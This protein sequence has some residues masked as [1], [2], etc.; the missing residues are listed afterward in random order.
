MK[1]LKL[2]AATMMLSLAVAPFAL[3][4]RGHFGGGA[5]AGGG[6]GFGGAPRMEGGAQPARSQM[7]G[8]SGMRQNFAG[9]DSVRDNNRDSGYRG[10]N[11]RDNS[12]R[13]FDRNNG[14]QYAAPRPP[15]NDNMRMRD[16]GREDYGDRA[17]APREASWRG[18]DRGRDGGRFVPR[19]GADGPRRDDYRWRDGRHE[20]DR[21]HDGGRYD[22]HWGWAARGGYRGEFISDRYYH[23]YW[24]P[25]HG[26]CFRSLR[27]SYYWGAPRYYYSGYWISLADPIPDYWGD[28]YDDDVYVEY[29][30]GGYYLLNRRW[31][32][33]PGVAISLWLR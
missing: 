26:F 28:W 17:A 15:A 7:R 9:R 6:R 24:G 23:R 27:V 18:G 32:D 29:Y 11:Y 14:R 13:D 1:N 19:P 21:W 5:P 4:Q 12:G 20:D 3:A 2:Y 30:D 31:P 22:H 16:G 10:N 8:D 25:D 33:R